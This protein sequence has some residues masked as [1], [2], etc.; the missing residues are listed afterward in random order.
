MTQF[1]GYE[2]PDGKVGV[3]NHLLV[4]APIDCSYEPAKKIAEQVED[5]VAITQTYGCGNDSMLVHNLAGTALNPN[6]AGVLIVGLGCETLTGEI[7]MEKIKPSGKPVYNIT[8]QEEG[9]TLKTHEKGVRI[10]QK[11]KQELAEL[12]REPFPLS[13]LTLAVECG[14]SDAT[15]G[16][17]A[18]PAVGV[19]ADKLIEEGGSV[20]FGETQEMCGT[21]HVL[22]ARAV[23]KNVADSIYEII[24]DQEA[25]QKAMGIDS[26]WMSKGN[27]DG[28]L[29][30]I[31]EK[32]LGAVRKGGTKPIQGV[33]YNDWD[34]FDA[35]TKSGL[36]LMD[37]PGWDVPS[38]THMVASGAQIVCFTS[39]R[40][41]TTG[42]AIAPVIKITGNP[43]TYEMMPDNMDIN[44]GTI[45]DGSESLN[46]V[47]QRIFN[48]IVQTANGRQTKA[49]ALGYKDFIVFKRSR[50]AEHML[51]H[52]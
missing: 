51:G 4:I 8:I 33:L 31:E 7:L 30:T 42:H 35:P 48:M 34:R 27:I 26:R 24:E 5:A 11:M 52:C 49:E 17:A 16:L 29:T 40:G 32:S 46:S 6:V 37:G 13:K 1:Y 41:S 22:A 28:G 25:R 23:N 43:S 21:Q 10:L 2:R 15:S 39:G 45:L 12:K 47:G 36:Y 3:R 38:V 44:A 9:G 19:A 20:M 50:E 18:N 14:G